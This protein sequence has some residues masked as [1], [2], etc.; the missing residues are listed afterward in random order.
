MA[1]VA[2][3]GDTTRRYRERRPR[4]DRIPL[5]HLPIP[6]GENGDE[7]AQSSSLRSSTRTIPNPAA[8][9]RGGRFRNQH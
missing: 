2:C 4:V 9:A 8:V 7:R 6:T 3:Q 1:C 5:L